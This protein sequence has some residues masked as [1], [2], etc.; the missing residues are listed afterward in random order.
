MNFVWWHVSAIT[1]QMIMSTYWI[2][3]L[4]CHWFMSTCQIIMSILDKNHHNSQLKIF[5]LF[6]VNATNSLIS[7]KLT[8]L[9]NNFL[10][11]RHNFRQVDIMIWQ[12]DIITKKSFQTIMSTCLWWHIS[13]IACQIIISTCQIFM[14]TCQLFMLTCQIIMS[15]CLKISSQLVAK[16]LI[17]ISCWCP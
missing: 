9:I 10:T 7:D 13:A 3:M 14:L 12:V 16:Y 5:F 15:T 11:S 1:C 17:F 6:R 2:F 4:T 8:S